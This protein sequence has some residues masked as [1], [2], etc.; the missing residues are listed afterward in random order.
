MVKDR[1]IIIMA[2]WQEV[3]FNLLNGAI[4]SDVGVI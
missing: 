1:V 2:E 4:V 3:V